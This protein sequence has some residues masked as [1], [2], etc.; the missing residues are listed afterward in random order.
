MDIA[1]RE[2]DVRHAFFGGRGSVLFEDAGSGVEAGDVALGN[3]F[4]EVDCDGT[5]STADI[6]DFHAW[7]EMREEVSC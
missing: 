7:T 3:E 5:R 4:R 1:G 6:E 2:F